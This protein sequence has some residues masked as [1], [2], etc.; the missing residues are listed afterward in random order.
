M[1]RAVIFLVAVCGFSN[2]VN[3]QIATGGTYS[4]EQGV[5]ANGGGQSSGTGYVVDGTLA[6]S[7]AGGPLMGSPYNL[8]SGF[9]EGLSGPTPTSTAT[10]T[11]TPTD[12]PTA[13][14]T[15]TPT[16]A[17][18]PTISGVITYGN[19]IGNPVPPRFVKNVSLSSTAGSPAV[20]PVITGTPGTYLLMGF[21][22]G[23]YTIKPAKPG[24]VNGAIT[25]NDAARVAQ[26]V[27]G[28]VPFVSLNQK[29]A[30]DASGNGTVS[31]NDAALIARF[32]AGL[33]GTG[34][35]GQWRFFTA[36]LPGAPTAPLPTPPYNDSRTYASV[37]SSLAGEDYVALLIGEAS[38]NYNPA[39]HPR[40]AN[41]PERSIAVQ[42]PQMVASTGKEITVPVSVQGAADKEII[43]YEFDL[44]YDASV[45]QP[46]KD[47][48]DVSETASRGLSVVTNAKEP[49]LLRV[50]VYGPMPIDEDGVLLNLRFAAV[51][52]VGSISPLSFERMIFNEGDPAVMATNG[53]I[54][55]SASAS[56]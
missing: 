7:L 30:S 37:A 9:W 20:G 43:S 6:Q 40:P 24:G 35:V 12:T 46:M 23:S 55:L 3:A 28:S 44:R 19:A 42:L 26:G 22:A 14:A 51:G 15:N 48:V 56:D 49:G 52:E 27:S 47:P 2:L 18:T 36:N 45:I 13:T 8:F 5:I 38:G 32:A 10:P 4:L 34:N 21:G 39:T 33:T 41:G 54:E 16:P 50:V 17:D 1:K 29:F 25:S 53:R 31:S 11:N